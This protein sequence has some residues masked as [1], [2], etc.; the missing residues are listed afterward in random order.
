MSQLATQVQ[1]NLPLF[2]GPLAWDF[3]RRQY[4]EQA[5]R[6]VVW[7]RDL[8]YGDLTDKPAFPNPARLIEAKILPRSHEEP[9]RSS[10]TGV[11]GV[12]QN[13][14]IMTP[15]TATRVDAPKQRLPAP[16]QPRVLKDA[17][18]AARSIDSAWRTDSLAKTAK[19]LQDARTLEEAVNAA[20][21]I[22]DPWRQHRRLHRSQISYRRNR[23]WRLPVSS[24]MLG[25]A[26]R[27]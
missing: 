7:G 8:G 2:R 19:Q 14:G 24:K 4:G 20:R 26:Q 16:V 12:C 25:Y 10:D 18:G 1:P 9:Q 21:G 6:P 22:S 13:Q 15:S 27:R 5:I 23:L 11:S 3:M 17:P